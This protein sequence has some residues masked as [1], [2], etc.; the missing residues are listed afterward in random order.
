MEAAQDE[1]A[2]TRRVLA[3]LKASLTLEINKSVSASEVRLTELIKKQGSKTVAN[4]KQVVK[5]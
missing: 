5:G 3:N 4:V 2:E 1:G